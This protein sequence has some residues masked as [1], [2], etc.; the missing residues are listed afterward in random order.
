[1]WHQEW[2]ASQWTQELS[3]RILGAESVGDVN[4]EARCDLAE[5]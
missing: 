3:C 1:M 4:G 5:R 2:L